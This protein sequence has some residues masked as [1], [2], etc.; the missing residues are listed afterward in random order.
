MAQR[1]KAMLFSYHYVQYM[2][3]DNIIIDNVE[4]RLQLYLCLVY[5][6]II[7]VTYVKECYWIIFNL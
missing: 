2:T 1:L 4:C 6:I 3:N 5:F 7:I